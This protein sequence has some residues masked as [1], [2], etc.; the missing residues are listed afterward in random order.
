MKVIDADGVDAAL[1]FPGLID[2]LAAA[3][4]GGV[5][6]PVRHHHTI[7]RAGVDATTLLMPAWTSGDGAFLGAKIVN[8]FPDNAARGLPSIHGVYVLMSGDTGAPLAVMDGTRITAWR[9]AAASALASRYLSGP[10]SSRLVMAGAG[11]LAPFLIRAHAS[12]RP[13]RHVTLWNRDTKRADALARTMAHDLQH[14]G[15][16]L[17]VTANLESAVRT[18]DIVSCATLSP[19]PIVRGAWLRPGA[20]LDLVGAYRP[21][22]RESDDEAVHRARLFC[23]TRGG[24]MREGGDLAIPLASGLVTPERIEADFFDLCA[25]TFVM[26]RAPEDITLFK[27]TGSAIED[28]AAAALVWRSAGAA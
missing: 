26:R 15:V 14:A 16:S 1:T 13:I 12:V 25:G 17:E 21:T 3:F 6:A 27:S 9:T 19:E 23:D 18:A 22:M 10:E 20:H 7:P 24:A 11:A 8:V 28:L 5:T 4:S 2:A